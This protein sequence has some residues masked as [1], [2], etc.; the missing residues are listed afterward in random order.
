MSQKLPDDV[1]LFLMQSI[2]DLPTDVKTSLFHFS[3]FGASAEVAFVNTLE[4]ALDMRDLRKNLDIAVDEGLLEKADDQYRFSHDRIQEA[5]YNTVS[6]HERCLV[7]VL[8]GMALASFS[9]RESDHSI[10]FTAAN[11]LILGGPNAIQDMS[12]SVT[13]AALNM[14]A[15]KKAMEMSDFGAAYSYFN[16][17]ISFLRE[18]HWQ[19][20]YDLSLELFELAAKCALTNGHFAS[21][22]LLSDQVA[23][24]VRCFEDG[25]NVMYFATCA[26][27]YSTRLL[28][29]I[30]QSL[31]ILSKLGIDLQQSRS[32]EECVQ[33]TK[34]SLSTDKR[35]TQRCFLH[36]SS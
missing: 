36:S 22:K 35:P 25:L 28:D 34:M 5:A 21:L 11:Q 2:V 18:G 19:E 29:S 27:A 1:A 26:L 32:T 6:A 16:N 4:R 15:G 13:A 12:Q 7:H 9:I 20:H 31:G 14:R 23:T 33:D 10:L 17:G 30:Q 24:E 3:C 8:Y